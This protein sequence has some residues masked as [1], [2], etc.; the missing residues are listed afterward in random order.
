MAEQLN[1]RDVVNP[2][3]RSSELRSRPAAELVDSQ[4]I[5]AFVNEGVELFRPGRSEGTAITDSGSRYSERRA[6]ARNERSVLGIQRLAGNAAVAQLLQN[7]RSPADGR[8]RGPAATAA[9]PALQRTVLVQR[10]LESDFTDAVMLDDYSRAV[11]LLNQMA[12]APLAARI[13]QQPPEW[14]LRLQRAAVQANLARV[15]T[16]I[17]NMQVRSGTQV[18]TFEGS[19]M[20]T[21]VTLFQSGVAISKDVRFVRAGRFRSS[22]DF[23]SLKNRVIDSVRTNLTNRFHLKIETPGGGPPQQGDG[24]YTIRVNFIDNPSAAY[25]MTLH[26]QRHGR[27]GM[28][29]SSGNVFELGQA[30]ETEPPEIGLAHEGAHVLLGARDEYADARHPA[31]PVFTD[32]SLMG[33]FPNE[34]MA[35]AQLKPRH[36]GALVRL[37]GGW[38]PGRTVSIIT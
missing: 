26:G 4:D 31:R 37:V 10:D 15:V 2:D 19:T 24:E 6:A 16:A 33:D 5:S 29:D 12:D 7:A 22:G 8:K 30:G 20:R 21:P 28:S 9:P 3:K 36:F 11:T 34:G 1:Q 25:S 13:A 35:Q 17:R 27:M 23:D 32:H 18:D 14:L 38:F